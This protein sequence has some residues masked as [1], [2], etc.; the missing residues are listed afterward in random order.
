MSD[1]KGG[2]KPAVKTDM[3]EVESK[4]DDDDVDAEADGI[5]DFD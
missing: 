5:S 3:D 1:G 4:A 2:K